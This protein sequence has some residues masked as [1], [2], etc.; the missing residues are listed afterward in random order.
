M[1]KYIIPSCFLL[2]I[3]TSSC[4]KE[5]TFETETYAKPAPKDC[6]KNCPEL[7]M[8]YLV[9]KNGGVVSDSINNKLFKVYKEI[10]YF[11]EKQYD[12]KTY[13]A[14][15]D[16]F[17]QSYAKLKVDFPED[18]FGWEGTVAS[19]VV[20][21]SDKLINIVTESYVFTGG[22]HG[23]SGTRSLI[24]DAFTG[25]SIPVSDLFLDK[26]K[27]VKFA[28]EKFRKK[29]DLPDSENIN[30]KGF[31]FEEDIF[32][33][34]QNVIF[35][36]DGIVLYYNIYEIAAYADGAKELFIPYS[37]ADQYLATK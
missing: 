35:K 24:F 15:G 27:F 28:E 17:L 18:S 25:K 20:Y 37:E 23:Y 13:E 16:A 19:K 3:L 11:G 29:Y 31:M 33:L 30:S 14:L 12:V 1:M 22:A 5:M 10:I 26:E 21:T 32:V 9:A 4:S 6:K 36:E 2:L 34:P 7:S 8:S